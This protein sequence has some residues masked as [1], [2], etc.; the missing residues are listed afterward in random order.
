MKKIKQIIKQILQRMGVEQ[1][2]LAFP[3]FRYSFYSQNGEDGVIEFIV[4]KIPSIP[5]FVVD[6]G[7]NDGV[8]GSNSRMLIEKYSFGGFLIEPFQPAFLKLKELYSNNQD[9][10]LSDKAVG[11]SNSEAGLINWHGHFEKMEMP[12]EDVNIVLFEEDLPKEIGFLSIDIDGGDNDVLKVIDWNRFSP[13]FVI[14]EIDSSSHVN[15]Q[16]QI[17]IMDDAGYRPILHIGNVFYARKD[18]LGE[19][20]F[21]WKKRLPGDYGFFRR[22][23]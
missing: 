3:I 21:N 5:K 9:V 18:V 6:I 11:A 4:K 15:L 20:L 22:G 17:N 13:Y 16:E 2:R 8:I 23:K 1:R 19:F 12:I 10:L 14:A 7:A